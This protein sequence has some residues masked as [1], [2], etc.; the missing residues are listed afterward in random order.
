MKSNKH[1]I[2]YLRTVDRLS[3]LKITQDTLLVSPAGLLRQSR[4]QT[5]Q[6]AVR[7]QLSTD[8]ARC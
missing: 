8:T 1:D 5:S 6:D 3:S 2:R 7:P 4:S